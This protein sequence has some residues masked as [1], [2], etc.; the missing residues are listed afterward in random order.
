MA[1]F[2]G[3]LSGTPTGQVA[4]RAR[5][6]RSQSHTCSRDLVLEQV[7]SSRS[8][9]PPDVHTGP[10]KLNSEAWRG[11]TQTRRHARELDEFNYKCVK[12]LH[13]PRRSISRIWEP[14]ILCCRKSVALTSA[15]MSTIGCIGIRK[16]YTAEEESAL[17][18]VSEY[19]MLPSLTIFSVQVLRP[20]L[21]ASSWSQG[22]PIQKFVVSRR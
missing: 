8:A 13:K 22:K 9:C 21:C 10:R 16:Q 20:A 17:K 15:S 2:F 14:I 6:D 4:A 1:T 11:A 3:R 7:N 5:F 19:A 18:C 12:L